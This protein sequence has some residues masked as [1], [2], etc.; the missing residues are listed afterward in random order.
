MVKRGTGCGPSPR[1]EEGFDE[2]Q[3]VT[4]A[5]ANESVVEPFTAAGPGAG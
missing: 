1:M 3:A 4:L 2:I 5:P